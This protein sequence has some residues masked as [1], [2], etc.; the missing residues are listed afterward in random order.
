MFPPHTPTLYET[1]QYMYSNYE[2]RNC[3]IK[4]VLLLTKMPLAELKGN[5]HPCTLFYTSS[6]IFDVHISLSLLA[7]APLCYLHQRPEVVYTLFKRLYIR[8]ISLVRKQETCAYSCFLILC[9]L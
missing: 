4:C 1:L 5:N 6:G 9:I 2:I 3:V 8:C 7:V